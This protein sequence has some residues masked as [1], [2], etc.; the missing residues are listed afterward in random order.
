M[1][2]GHALRFPLAMRAV[3]F[4][5]SLERLPHNK[6]VFAGNAKGSPLSIAKIML[7]AME[8]HTGKRPIIYTEQKFHREVL[9]DEF[10]DHYFWLR[11]VAAKPEAK[12][13]A[14]ETGGGA[15]KS[16]DQTH[17]EAITHAPEQEV[18]SAF[19][20]EQEAVPQ[21]SDEER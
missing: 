18:R 12:Y 4:L 19:E 17:A 10:P 7:A 20:K 3:A 1:K 8:A 21:R 16:K 15:P 11:S 5:T 13:R 6:Y 14:R 9:E 2:A